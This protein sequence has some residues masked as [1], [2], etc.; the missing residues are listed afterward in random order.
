[1]ATNLD[2]IDQLHK[3]YKQPEDDQGENGLL[4]QLIKTVLS[5]SFC[6]HNNCA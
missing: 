1:M 6:A 2:L 5:A 4:N 3:D